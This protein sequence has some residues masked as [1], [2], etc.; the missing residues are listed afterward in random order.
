MG[1]RMA[2]RP[3]GV[4]DDL[5]GLLGVVGTPRGRVD[6]LVVTSDHQT[7][8]RGVIC[9]LDGVGAIN[10]NAVMAEQGVQKWA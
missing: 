8:H 10:R 5:F 7:Y 4:H 2:P 9:E 1:L 3:P 6:L